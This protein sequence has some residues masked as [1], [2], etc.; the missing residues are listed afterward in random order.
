[1]IRFT[2]NQ[3]YEDI[4]VNE[5]CSL[6]SRTAKED[7]S[8]REA[9]LGYG[10]GRPPGNGS[11]P[12]DFEI[13]P[14]GVRGNVLYTHPEPE[15]ELLPLL[16]KMRSIYHCVHYLGHIEY[17]GEDFFPELPEFFAELQ[18]PML[19]EAG[20]FRVRCDRRGSHSFHSPQVERLAGGILQD[21]YGTAVDLENPDC[22][23]RVDIFGT[24]LF[25]GVRL[26]DDQNVR[27]FDKPFHQRISTRSVV[28]YGMLNL[29]G[30]LS[31]PGP[32]LDPFCGSG[33]ILLEAANLLPD[34]ELLGCDIHEE[35]VEGSRENLTRLGADTRSHI[36]CGDAR[37][38]SEVFPPNSAAYI[39]TD[40]PLGIR[41]GRQ[42]N[43]Y[44]FYSNILEEAELVLQK[45]GRLLLLSARHRKQ[46]NHAVRNNGNF[47]ILHVRV[48][49]Y[50]GI[51]PA[52]FLLQKKN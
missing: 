37:R 12:G 4:V 21:R 20:T 31:K 51:Y 16:T 33:T 52:L 48:I 5:V 9:A 45:E 40:P 44:P 18:I 30:I 43:F 8:G 47:K 36:V 27:R 19:R 38:L 42:I 35:A 2:T 24:H 3:G 23:V 41:M 1:M 46:L 15:E 34:I 39:V 32:L 17:G 7:F 28:A 13:S 14:F 50:G 25:A 11:A 49:E 26:S 22:D 10:S 6:L 29:S